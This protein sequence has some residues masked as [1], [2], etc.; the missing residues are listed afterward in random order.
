MFY[1]CGLP[2]SKDKSGIK[3]G[4]TKNPCERCLSMWKDIV[5]LRDIICRV[6][7]DREAQYEAECAHSSYKTLLDAEKRKVALAMEK[8]ATKILNVYFLNKLWCMLSGLHITNGSSRNDIYRIFTVEPLH[9]LHLGI[10]KR[11][12]KCP[13]THLSSVE[14]EITVFKSGDKTRRASLYKTQFL[15]GCNHLMA[16]YKNDFLFL[17]VRFY[18]STTPKNR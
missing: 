6:E 5:M 8:Q 14:R 12:K 9:T 3:H 2:K 16:A 4:Q 13:K 11:L 10:L 1:G 7:R 17:D 15:H 18:Y